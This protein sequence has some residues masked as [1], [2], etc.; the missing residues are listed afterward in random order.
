MFDELHLSLQHGM[1]VHSMIVF[2]L[3]YYELSRY[4]GLL[5]T[6][7]NF[8]REGDSQFPELTMP[9]DNT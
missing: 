1:Y 6:D 8:T 3:P 9:Y 4:S 2:Q 7:S 5:Y